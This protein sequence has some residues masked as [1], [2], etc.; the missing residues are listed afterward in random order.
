MT[1]DEFVG[2]LKDL[3]KP[4][5]D[6]GSNREYTRGICELIADIDGIPEVEHAVRAEQ[7]RIELL[8]DGFV[9]TSD[10]KCSVY[11]GKKEIAKSYLGEDGYEVRILQ[12]MDRKE[13]INKIL[14]NCPEFCEANGVS[15]GYYPKL[16]SE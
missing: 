9:Y 3:A 11:A 12:G 16:F 15:E 14:R 4:L 10:G 6:D 1:K 8:S 13:T 2:K 5:I 7:I